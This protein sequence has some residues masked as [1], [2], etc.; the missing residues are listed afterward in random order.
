M[1]RIKLTIEYA[2][3]AYC[4]WQRQN[5]QMSVQQKIEE[6]GKKIFG[7]DISITG[8]GRT[9][10]GVSA[11]GQVAHFD[12]ETN[13]PPQNIANALNA[14]LPRDIS[15]RKSEEV[16]ED[17][18]ARYDAK[19][20]TYVYT[21]Y[22]SRIRN[23][24]FAPI[25]TQIGVHLNEEEMNRAAA[26]LIGEHD[27]CSFMAAGSDVKTT[28]RTIYE[29]KVERKGEYVVFTVCGSGFLYNQVRIMAGTLI[30]IGKGKIRAEEMQ[31]II[32]AKSRFAAA[33]TAKA[34]GLMLKEIEY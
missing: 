32:L 9:D 16:G 31:S 17:F 34:E 12:I 8:A 18:H 6:A 13:I 33:P 14:H 1:A 4:G 5:G 30:E 3:G 23:A 11:L 24:V 20:K 21:I 22:N 25:S 29:A 10:T 26:Y 7:K 28:V 19:K 27:F 15:I 2:G